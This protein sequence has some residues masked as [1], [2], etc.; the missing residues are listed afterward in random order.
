MNNWKN[1]NN[2]T[3]KSMKRLITMLAMASM[4]MMTMAEE[5]LRSGLDQ[6]DVDTSLRPGDDVYGYAWGVLVKKHPLAAADSRYCCVDQR[7]ESK[8]K[9]INDI[10]P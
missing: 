2:Q 7:Q 4:T 1:F 6:T 5:P 8:A 9:R 10:L 3:I